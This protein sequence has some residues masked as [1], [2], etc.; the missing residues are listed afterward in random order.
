MEDGLTMDVDEFDTIV[1]D[2]ESKKR[3]A[4][5]AAIAEVTKKKKAQNHLSSRRRSGRGK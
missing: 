2:A 1:S 3:M 5:Q 4:E